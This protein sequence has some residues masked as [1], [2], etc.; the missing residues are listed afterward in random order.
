MRVVQITMLGLHAHPPDGRDLHGIAFVDF[1]PLSPLL[2]NFPFT[3][4]RPGEDQSR[5]IA[6]GEAKRS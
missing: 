1:G 2:E 5:R 6:I 3:V 4:R